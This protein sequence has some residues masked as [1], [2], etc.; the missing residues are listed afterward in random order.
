MRSMTSKLSGNLTG[1]SMDPLQAISIIIKVILSHFEPGNPGNPVGQANKIG[2]NVSLTYWVPWVPRLEMAGYDPHDDLF[3]L[4][5]VR[6]GFPVSFRVFIFQF[7]DPEH[8]GNIPMVPLGGEH[9][10]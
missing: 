2:E 7:D 6:G 4:Y 1:A 8:H 5:R 3:D 10:S 9:G